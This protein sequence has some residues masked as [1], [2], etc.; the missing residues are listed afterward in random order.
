MELNE[1][2]LEITS[3]IGNI[4]DVKACA[5]RLVKVVCAPGVTQPKWTVFYPTKDTRRPSDTGKSMPPPL[6]EIKQNG[7]GRNTQNRWEEGRNTHSIWEERRKRQS[8]W[9]EVSKH[10]D[11]PPLKRAVTKSDECS[12]IEDGEVWELSDGEWCLKESY[13]VFD[14]RVNARGESVFVKIN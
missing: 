7:E 14:I 3:T 1:R 11:V 2:F 6:C 4:T 9:E 5:R 10:F 12:I 13:S 8:S